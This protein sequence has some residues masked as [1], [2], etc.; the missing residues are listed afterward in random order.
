VRR[1]RY[2]GD[3]TPICDSVANFERYVEWR[4]TDKGLLAPY[5]NNTAL[6]GL[7]FEGHC[8]K[9]VM[10]YVLGKIFPERPAKDFQWL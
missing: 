6:A 8:K 4:L 2:G 1:L 7:Q 9:H 5:Y 3:S 10:P